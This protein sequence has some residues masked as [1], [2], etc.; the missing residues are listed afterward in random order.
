MQKMLPK[1]RKCLVV[2][3]IIQ[4]GYS[5]QNIACFGSLRSI[6]VPMEVVAFPENVV[7]THTYPKK[8]RGVQVNTLLEVSHFSI[9]SYCY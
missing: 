5:K 4:I 8:T 9:L 1:S 7:Q 3:E 2:W 6:L